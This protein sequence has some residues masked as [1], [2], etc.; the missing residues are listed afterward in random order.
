MTRD[1]DELWMLNGVKV[2]LE[3]NYVEKV[4]W[5]NYGQWRSIWCSRRALFV[6]KFLRDK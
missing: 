3:S 1:E 2:K 5:G 6:L 4:D